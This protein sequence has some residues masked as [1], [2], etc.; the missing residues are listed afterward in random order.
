M[1]E[2]KK[3]YKLFINNL[4]FK[5]MKRTIIILSFLFTVIAIQAG[6]FKGLSACGS[7]AYTNY[8]K[9]EA[10]GFAQANFQFGEIPFEPKL[11]LAYH[12]FPTDYKYLSGLGTESVGVFLEGAVYPFKKI[13]YTGGRLGIDINWLNN[14]AMNTLENA[15]EPVAQVFPGFRLCA[16]A[17]FDIPI[18]RR[19][20]LRISCMPGWQFYAISDN[21]EISSGGSSIDINSSNAISYNKF[22]FQV[23]AGIAVRLWNK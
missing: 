19:I 10:E 13:F 8:N 1:H 15:N 17:G 20:S 7:A 18:S 2:T 3:Q 6:P 4:Q 22:I 12:T 11:G 9:F 23:N 14:R 16:V 5:I 21:W